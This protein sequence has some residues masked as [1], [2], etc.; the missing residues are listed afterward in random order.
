MFHPHG[1]PQR[2]LKEDRRAWD[3]SL[4]YINRKQSSVEWWVKPL[5]N[6]LNK[7]TTTTNYKT[8]CITSLSQGWLSWLGTVSLRRVGNHPDMISGKC[9]PQGLVGLQKQ[10]WGDVSWRSTVTQVRCVDGFTFRSLFT[11]AS[12]IV[13]IGWLS[14]AKG[15]HRLLGFQKHFTGMSCW[16]IKWVLN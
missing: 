12:P 13:P 2:Y 1:L 5:L 4:L 16:L 15:Q 9:R 11:G 3:E 14:K 7:Q 8:E 6:V 10:V